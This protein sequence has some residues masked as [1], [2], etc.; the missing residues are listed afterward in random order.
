MKLSVAGWDFVNDMA[1]K[2]H[3]NDG[4]EIYEYSLQR[5]LERLFALNLEDAEKYR[6][7]SIWQKL[8]L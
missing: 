1:E 2:Y 4:C 3:V 6:L 5:T 7:K 8:F